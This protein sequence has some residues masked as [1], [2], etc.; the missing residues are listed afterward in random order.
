MLRQTPRQTRIPAIDGDTAYLAGLLH[1]IGKFLLD[2]VMPKSFD[3]LIEQARAGKST[4]AKVEQANLGIDHTILAKRFAQKL[5][6]A[7]RY[8]I[9]PLLH[10]SRAGAIPQMPQ[11]RIAALV[12][13][14]DVMVRRMN[15]ANREITRSSFPPK[16]SQ[17]HSALTPDISNRFSRSCSIWSPLKA[18]R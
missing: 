16:L 1:D 12:E 9:G 3:T 14:A 11:A 5:A 7:K 4:F 15:I 2:E 10:H 18:K 17:G 13:L 6:P 8:H